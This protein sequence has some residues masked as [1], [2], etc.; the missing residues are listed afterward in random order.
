MSW[1]ERCFLSAWKSA[2]IE[3]LFKVT[4]SLD[5]F[6]TLDLKISLHK[7]RLEEHVPELHINFGPLN[8]FPDQRDTGPESKFGEV[9]GFEAQNPG[10]VLSS[11][12]AA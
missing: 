12:H 6:R 2:A 5:K 11:G 4:V 8:C 7:F 10:N 1:Y 3:D 9:P